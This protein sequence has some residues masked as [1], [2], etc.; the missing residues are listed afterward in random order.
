MKCT[1]CHHKQRHDIDYALLAENATFAALSQKYGPS[2]SALYRHK[3]H[4][5]EKVRRARQRFKDSQQQGCLF[6]LNAFLDNIQRAVQSAEADGNVDQVLKGSHVGSR[7][8]HQI[9]RLEVPL[10]L[11]TVYRLMASP[12]WTSQ[13][14]LL[15]TSPRIIT[16]LH[17]VLADDLFFPCPEPEPLP[18][19]L[20]KDDAEADCD[21]EEDEETSNSPE[22]CDAN[23]GSP[24]LLPVNSSLATSLETGN[25]KPETI[26]EELETLPPDLLN[27]LQKAFPSLVPSQ[28]LP[29]EK[30]NHNPKT[31]REKSAKLPKKTGPSFENS[32]INQEDTLIKKNIRKNATS[33]GNQQFE[34]QN[35]ELETPRHESLFD[36]LRR[37]WAESDP[38]PKYSCHSDEMYEEYLRENLAADISSPEPLTGESGPGLDPASASPL[39]TQKPEPD[40]PPEKVTL[41]PFDHPFEYNYAV[42]HG[43]RIEDR[44]KY[45]PDPRGVYRPGTWVTDVRR[46]G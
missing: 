20:A 4:L 13:D 3:K 1:V 28:S 23:V 42:T 32:I 45:I 19:S 41:N 30:A 18:A 46:H 24:G 22:R 12:Q 34:T 17:Q 8:I 39:E 38:P 7:I 11:D 33:T 10:E 35:P 26:P 16:D 37:K 27:L 5:E 15:P 31:Q 2:I 25:Q 14:S 6:K 36:R 29:L 43:H 9:Q 44:P 21:D 40:T